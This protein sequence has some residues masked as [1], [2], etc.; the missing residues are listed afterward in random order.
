M[1]NNKKIIQMLNKRQKVF[2]SAIFLL[3]LLLLYSA[4]SFS[5]QTITGL[6]YSDKKPVTITIMDGKIAGIKRADKMPEGKQNYFVAPGMIDNQVNGYAGVSFTFLGGELTA[7]GVK[8]AT[9]AL[10]KDGVTTYLPT[11]TTSSNEVLKKNFTILGREKN[12]PELLGSIAGF[13]LEGPFISPLDGFRGAHPLK[14]VRKPDWNEFL[15]L[16]KASGSN[17]IE[18]TIAPETEGAMEFIS[19]CKEAGIIVALGHHNATA[20]IVNEAINRGAVIATHFGNGCANM[21][22]RHINP[23]WPQL[24]DDRL[25]ISIIGDGFHLNPEEI[26]VFYKVKGPDKTIITSDVTSYSSLP[27]GKYLN[28]EGDTIELTP[29]GMLRYPAQGVLAG[30]ASPLKKGVANVMKVTGCSMEE[31]LRMVTTNPARLYHLDDRGALE[32]G[33]RADIILFQVVD[34]QLVIINTYVNGK[35]VYENKDF[36]KK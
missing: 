4:E 2:Y 25:M 35:L 14:Y 13:H 30:S 8:K 19:K 23:L 31:A 26:R 10:W 9:E 29:E 3:S 32:V 16:N 21:I 28:A 11:L 20:D 6:L 24:A 5:Q 27:P 7:E 33:K 22:N 1:M 12:N 18:I 17:I 36:L 34:N 15:E